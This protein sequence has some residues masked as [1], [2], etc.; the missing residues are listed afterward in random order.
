MSLPASLSP[1][2]STYYHG[3]LQG[4]RTISM[5]KLLNTYSY[6]MYKF[7]VCFPVCVPLY[8]MCVLTEPLCLRVLYT[9]CVLSYLLEC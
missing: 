9:I 7:T 2:C 6:V 1:A 4:E 5:Q 8:L 3:H